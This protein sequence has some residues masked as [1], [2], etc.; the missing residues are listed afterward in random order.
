MKS[1]YRL[2][3]TSCILCT[4][5]LAGCGGG[6]GSPPPTLYQ[7]AVTA[8]TTGGTVTSTP[9]GISC[10]T[11]CS[12]SFANNT[13]VTLTAT[14]G[15]NYSF[16]G[17]SGSCSG[18][19][20][21]SLSMTAA[22][23]VTAAFIPAYA[24]T[25]TMVGTGT[26]TSSPAGINCPT[27]CSA[28]FAQNT[29]VTLSAT[30]G[31][32]YTFGGWSGNCSGTGACIVTMTAAENVAV[33]FNPDYGLTVTLAGLGTGTVTS[34]PA[35]INCPT[36]CSASFAQDTQ[37]SLS[38]TPASNNAFGGWSGA[39]TGATTCSVTLNGPIAVTATFGSASLQSLNHIIIFAQENRSFDHYFGAMREYWAQNGIADQ[40]FDGLPQFNPASG[41]APLQGAVPSVP[42]CDPAQPYPAYS[43]CSIDTSN[44]IPSFH[45]TSTCQE[46]QSPFW[47]ENHVDWDYNAPTGT[48]P[49]ALNGFV[50]TAADDARQQ[51]P[52]LMDTNGIRAMGY[53]DGSDL[54]YYYFM[55]SNFATSDRWFSPVMDRTQINRMYL[56]AAT[57]AGHVH[58]LAAPETPLTAPVIFEELQNASITWKIYIDPRGT[59]CSSNP[60]PSCLYNYS[61][62]NQFT[63]GQTIL[64]SP[65]LSQN[66]VPMTQ[67]T[68]DVQNGTLP[69]V[70]L[71]EP[72]SS[73]GLDE[74]PNDYDTNSP[75]NVQA[76][77][78]FAES[79]INAL[80]T[81]SSWKDSAMIFTY[82]EAGGFYD[83]VSP[84][85]MPSPDGIQPMDLVAG[86]ICDATGQS[87]TGTCDFTY[88]G[89]RLPLIVISPFAKKNYVSHTVRDYTAILKLI[90][91]RFNLPALTKRDAA[92]ADMSEFFDFANMPWATPPSP[93]AQNTS[94]AC[95][96]A[97][98]TP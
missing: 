86:D 79:L 11:T 45:F 96:L 95:T 55:A 6:T 91:T 93:P 16:G 72:P 90:Q 61:Y 59:S 51:S 10:P 89:F 80:M 67:F 54:N 43:A 19:G 64:N 58:P 76:G 49:A 37:V 47:N 32:N 68:T 74:H 40:S 25:V 53:F 33:A 78:Q 62:I 8:P 9:A 66:L 92:Q 14:A 87:G 13:Q 36:T 24:L 88:T 77:A 56:L 12:A 28:S 85:P 82:D 15:T 50:L 17:W 31:N 70:A 27:T 30:A 21:C 3:W 57:S 73:V 22:Q 23:S 5:L 69:Q 97:P 18:T 29:Q 84:Q 42:G 38:E 1:R 2:W 52:P 98:P 63:Y 4:L 83:H 46:E 35:G 34:T 65:T 48:G 81:S 20:T 39:C 75:I 71:I 94:G 41:I 60:V 7:L 26:V 44:M